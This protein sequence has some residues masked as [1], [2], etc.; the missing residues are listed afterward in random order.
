MCVAG[1]HASFMRP[2]VRETFMTYNEANTA[3]R[4]VVT[5]YY[6]TQA[7]AQKASVD[8][9]RA[10]IPKAD[11]KIIAGQSAGA[12][13]TTSDDT[14]FW[15]SLKDMFLP[16]D[17]RHAYAEGLRRGGYVLSVTAEDAR[18]EHVLEILDA[19]GSVDIAQRE[20]TWRSEG[21]KGY[22][23]GTAAGVVA[24]AAGTQASS[25][26]PRGAVAPV[27]AKSASETLATGQDETIPVYEER[28]QVGKRDV[29]HGRVRLRSYVVETPVNEQVSLRRESVQVD[30]RPVDRVV[31]A[32]DAVFKERTIEVEERAEEA[33]IAKD[34]R[35]K[36]EVSLRKTAEDLVKNVTD[37]VR[38]TKVE[39]ED[40]RNG[41]VGT[42]RG[43]VAAQDAHLIIE[44]MDVVSSDGKTVG[45]VDHMDG[46]DRIK[47]TKTSSPDGQ[48]HFI[49]LAWVDHVDTHV[50]LNKA[51]AGVRSSW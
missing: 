6:D 34:V 43:F 40:T 28:L 22:E 11:I 39:I 36:E 45:V 8:L 26:A 20:T 24:G 30:R 1:A 47:L 18:Y 4:R 29:S 46:T 25:V 42:A 7:A 10:G 17:D 9:E 51:E 19:D 14:G 37:T 5:A 12:S 15:A 41:S 2:A 44:H 32:G 31:A 21:W 23:P 48:H 50:H 49:P 38:S 33:V 16:D 3:H 13:A 35:V 27:T